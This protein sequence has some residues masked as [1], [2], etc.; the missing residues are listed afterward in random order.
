MRNNTQSNASFE[1]KP[2]I[3]LYCTVLYCIVLYC[4]QELYRHPP[5]FRALSRILFCSTPRMRARRRHPPHSSRALAVEKVLYY[6][7]L[8][9]PELYKHST[10]RIWFWTKQPRTRRV[11]PCPCAYCIRSQLS[12]L[13]SQTTPCS[14]ALAAALQP[15]HANSFRAKK[16]GFS[17]FAEHQRKPGQL[18]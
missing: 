9:C 3:V 11:L 16:Q 4:R 8:H 1:T 5:N 14:I 15:C 2:K 10:S 12:D 17:D 18:F 7:V 13:N 6:T